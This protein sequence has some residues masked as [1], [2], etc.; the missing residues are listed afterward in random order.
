MRLVQSAIFSVVLKQAGL[1]G[2]DAC[3]MSFQLANEKGANLENL[4]KEIESLKNKNKSDDNI[5]RN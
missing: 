3:K 5:W 4:A 1:S 2:E